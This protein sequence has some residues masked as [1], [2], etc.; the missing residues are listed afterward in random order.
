MS[1]TALIWCRHVPAT[2]QPAG[3]AVPNRGDVF[4]HPWVVPKASTLLSS[5]SFHGG[6]CQ[7]SSWYKAAACC[8]EL[9]ALSFLFFSQGLVQ[10]TDLQEVPSTQSPPPPFYGTT[11]SSLRPAQPPSSLGWAEIPTTV[12]LTTQPHS[13]R[14]FLGKQ[15][16]VLGYFLPAVMLQLEPFLHLNGAIH[17]P[18]YCPSWYIWDGE[19]LGKG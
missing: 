18:P 7:N 8:R 13:C 19:T 6:L 17:K 16:R 9:S 11:R 5:T 1:P 10:T 4:L 12:P 2:S 15:T 14:I 3:H